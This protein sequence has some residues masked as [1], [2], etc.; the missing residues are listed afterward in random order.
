M[1]GRHLD[2]A[3][4]WLVDLRR[5]KGRILEWKAS[6][7][8]RL[9]KANLRGLLQRVSEG[10]FN[11]STTSIEANDW[12]HRMRTSTFRSRTCL[13]FAQPRG[14]R[15]MSID[16]SGASGYT[17]VRK[18]AE[19]HAGSQRSP[20]A[21]KK[22]VSGLPD[23]KRPNLGKSVLQ[24]ETEI[25]SWTSCLRQ[26]WERFRWRNIR[27][28]VL[29]PIEAWINHRSYIYLYISLVLLL[30]ASICVF[31]KLHLAVLYIRSLN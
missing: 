18:S 25:S 4:R 23:K 14:D 19:R 21:W 24:K 12:S 1:K 8:Y 3:S 30:K 5:R 20:S 31:T 11:P 16:Q 28:F 6:R 9:L 13:R 7:D 27:M 22:S 29:H 17:I 2:D 26:Q 15:S 10:H